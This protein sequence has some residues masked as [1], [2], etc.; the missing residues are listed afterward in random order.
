[1]G[2][3]HIYVGLPYFTYFAHDMFLIEFHV[4]IYKQYCFYKLTGSVTF[5]TKVA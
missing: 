4:Q 3:A 1:M 2:Q 5:I